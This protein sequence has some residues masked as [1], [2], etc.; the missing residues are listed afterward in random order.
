MAAFSWRG[1]GR[2]FAASL[3]LL[4]SACQTPAEMGVNAPAVTSQYF[5]ENRVYGIWDWNEYWRRD[6]ASFT[7]ISKNEYDIG[8]ASSRNGDYSTR[9][10]NISE[11][12]PSNRFIESA[13]AIQNGDPVSVVLSSVSLPDDMRLYRRWH[14]YIGNTV[15]DI[16]VAVIVEIEFGGSTRAPILAWYQRGISAGQALSLRNLLIYRQASWNSSQAP[17][18]RVRVIDVTADRNSA[19]LQSLGA[20]NQ[21]GSAATALMTSNPFASTGV[22]LA[23]S[24]ARLILANRQNAPVLDMSLQLYPADMTNASAHLRMSPLAVGRFLVAA[25]TRAAWRQHTN[26]WYDE[27]N[28]ELLSGRMPLALAE[29]DPR[30]ESCRLLTGYAPSPTTEQRVPGTASNLVNSWC[31]RRLEMGRPPEL[32]PAGLPVAIFTV[33]KRDLE[34]SSSLAALSTAWQNRITESV[35]TSA[36]GASLAGRMVAAGTPLLAAIAHHDRQKSLQSLSALVSRLRDTANGNQIDAAGQVWLGA[37]EVV[38]RATGCDVQT[39]TAAAAMMRTL[40]TMINRTADTT[41]P[42]SNGAGSTDGQ[43]RAWRIDAATGRVKIHSAQ[44]GGPMQ[45]LGH[46]AQRPFPCPA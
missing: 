25:G 12:I 22:D 7:P 32:Q 1:V 14:D 31:L 35:T 4:V 19:L 33:V 42:T 34:P 18:I 24:A 13:Q 28:A 3:A 20:A 17:R 36:S 26:L 8:F 16:D 30:W 39:A 43:E 37:V 44:R 2:A 46:E 41:S 38:H 40:S 23:F 6:G 9:L 45:V 15:S 11:V 27:A 5:P 21:L 10:L 29:L